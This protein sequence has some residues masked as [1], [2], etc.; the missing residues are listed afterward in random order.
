M[1]GGEG[2]EANQS[3]E[4]SQST[5]VATEAATPAT[6]KATEQAPATVAER[7]AKAKCRGRGGKIE[8]A[9]VIEEDE[10]PP[11]APSEDE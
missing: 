5:P 9:A 3:E 2:A 1:G 6:A 4:S 7:K 8:Q 10:G 11:S